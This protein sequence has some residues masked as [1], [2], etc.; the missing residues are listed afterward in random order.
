MFF[1]NIRSLFTL[2]AASI[3]MILINFL[4]PIIAARLNKRFGL[5]EDTIGYVF[6][7]PFFIYIVGCP[8][9][10]AIGDRLKRRIT[11]FIA[12]II[13]TIGVFLTGPS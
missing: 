12:F 6:A 11:I 5:K 3:T 7:I 9:I 10:S 1:T 2:I 8:I 13:Q 4:D